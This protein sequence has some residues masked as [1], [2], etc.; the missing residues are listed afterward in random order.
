VI[1]EVMAEARSAGIE[2]EL[3]KVESFSLFSAR[4]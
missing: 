3:P 4:R 1:A 2:N